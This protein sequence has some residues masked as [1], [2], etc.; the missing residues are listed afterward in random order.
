MNFSTKQTINAKIPTMF[1]NLG[2]PKSSLN[3][4]LTFSLSFISSL[5]KDDD[6]HIT[7]FAIQTYDSIIY[8]L[9]VANQRDGI[10]RIP[11]KQKSGQV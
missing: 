6:K 8:L 11:P 1:T 7:S 2:G 3:D 5:K 10:Y 4:V 9:K